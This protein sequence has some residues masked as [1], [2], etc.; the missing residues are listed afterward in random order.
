L[1]Q[2]Y[3]YGEKQWLNKKQLNSFRHHALDQLQKY[4]DQFLF[5]DAFLKE[6]SFLVD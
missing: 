2:T 4:K 1:Y 5:L 3:D 6:Y